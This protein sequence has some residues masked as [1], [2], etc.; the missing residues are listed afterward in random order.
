M[1][2]HI[3]VKWGA[4]AV[5]VIFT[6][7]GPGEV[8]GWLYPLSRALKALCPTADL[9]VCLLPCVFA[10]GAEKRVIAELGTIDRVLDRKESLRLILT[11][12]RPEGWSGGAPALVFHLGGEVALTVLLARRLGASLYA[13]AERPLP[14]SFLFRRVFYNGLNRLPQRIA[15]QA[16][17]LVGELMVDAARLRRAP[18][19]VGAKPGMRTVALYPGSREYLAE[20]L[21]PYYAF[22]VEAL[23]AKRPQTRWLIARADYV[24]MSLL[25]N[26]PPPPEGHR[27]P[28]L[29]LRFG[30][31]ERQAWL[32]TPAGVRIEIASAAEAMARADLALTIPGTNTGE[33]AA[34]GVPMVVVL[35]TYLG[36]MVPLPGLAGHLGRLPGVGRALKTVFGHRMLRRLPLLAQPNRRAGRMIVPEL[37]GEGLNS[38]IEAELLA[39]IDGD[40]T[41]LS[42]ALAKAMGRAGA[43]ERLSAEIAAFFGTQNAQGSRL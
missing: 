10:T 3:K 29:A 7:N 19:Q 18:E 25:R 40:N 34:A 6:V 20:P 13:Y 31:D 35:P 17:L 43:A 23:A 42:L 28:A 36:H 8:S 9:T 38:R 5:R 1:S 2:W 16:D 12:R 30:E 33:L 27:W 37:V 41:A 32:E 21:L 15:S 4:G 11:G 24:S 22:V 26:L 14:W 39:L